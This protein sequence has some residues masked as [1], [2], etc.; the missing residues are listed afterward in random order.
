MWILF[1]KRVFLIR[2]YY[3]TKF[4][5]IFFLIIELSNVKPTKKVIIFINNKRKS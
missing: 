5:N 2:K 4:P 1:I 3:I